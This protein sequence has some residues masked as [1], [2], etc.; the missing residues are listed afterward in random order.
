[1]S[2]RG[3]SVKSITLTATATTD[4]D[5]DGVTDDVKRLMQAQ[6]NSE[7]VQVTIADKDGMIVL[8]GYITQLPQQRSH[9]SGQQVP[10]SVTIELGQV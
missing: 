7:R 8:H 1:M 6:Q 10:Y 9:Q 2:A 5:N 3:V 4:T